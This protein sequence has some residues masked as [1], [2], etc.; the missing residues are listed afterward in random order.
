MHGPRPGE[1]RSLESGTPWHTPTVNEITGGWIPGGVHRVTEGPDSAPFHAF[2]ARFQGYRPPPMPWHVA[3]TTRAPMPRLRALP[4]AFPLAAIL[5]TFAACSS[6]TIYKTV[7]APAVTPEEDAS[8]TEEPDAGLEIDSSPP[9]PKPGI[10]FPSVLSRGGST[11]KAP[12][13]VPITFAGDPMIANITSFTQKIASSTYWSTLGAE[14]GVGPITV[15][16]TVTLSEAAPTNTTFDE[17]N[18]WVAAKV[19][20]TA[21]PFGAP[22]ESTLYAVFYPSSTT[23]QDQSLGKSCEAYGGYHEET[24]TAS[25]KKIGYAVMPRCAGIDDLTITASHEYFEWATDPFPETAPAFNRLDDAH[26]AWGVVMLGELGDLCTFLDTENLRPTELGFE[27]QRMWSNKASLA[28]KY[29][30]A[31]AKTSPYLQAIPLVDD[32]VEV[33][34]LQDQTKS[35]TTKAV[36]VPAGGSRSIDVVIY[37]DQAGT[38]QVPLRALSYADFQGGGQSS[39]VKYALSKDYAKVGE[40]IKVQI[41]ASAAATDDMLVMMAYTGEQSAHYWPVYVSVG[42]AAAR[43]N[44]PSTMMQKVRRSG[45]RLTQLGMGKGLLRPTALTP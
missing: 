9:K 23:I 40:T 44:V 42:P 7:P 10:T 3:C 2:C 30:C 21:A 27:V 14:Y 33:P 20:S 12:K 11:I 4:L 24:T 5:G 34:D 15:K 25:G 6:E 29:P 16:P 22:D 31:P 28:G 8:G 43:A 32:D 26:W 45:P 19:G 13:I 18:A 1:R 41:S 35:L 36:K 17:I 38:P 37:S 39:G